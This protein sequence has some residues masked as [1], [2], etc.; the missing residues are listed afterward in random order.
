MI[1]KDAW[2][3][4]GLFR[5]GHCAYKVDE[6]FPISIVMVE[7][8]IELVQEALQIVGC[9]VAALLTHPILDNKKMFI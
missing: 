3:C 7:M 9:R 5:F 1:T 8:I 2:A 6:A 4:E